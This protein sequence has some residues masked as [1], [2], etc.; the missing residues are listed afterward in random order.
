MTNPK[1]LEQL[2]QQKESLARR[3]AET[4]DATVKKQLDDVS[5]LYDKLQI[6][7]ALGTIEAA[8]EC[9][10]IKDVHTPELY[11]AL[12]TLATRSA[13]KWPF[14]EFRT[15]LGKPATQPDWERLNIALT[16]IRLAFD[17]FR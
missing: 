8:V 9:C 1:T 12:D 4:G 7:L 3:Y 16:G 2:A 11:S 15:A 17:G 5:R 6:T 13:V 10:R 14:Q